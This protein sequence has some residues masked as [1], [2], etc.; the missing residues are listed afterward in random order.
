MHPTIFQRI[1]FFFM[2]TASDFQLHRD[3]ATVNNNASNPGRC[4]RIIITED[5]DPEP[6]ENFTISFVVNSTQPKGVNISINQNEAVIIIQEND[7]K[8]HWFPMMWVRELHV[9]PTSEI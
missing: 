2:Y 4:F 9:C 1:F 7:S 3:L 8:N 5:S 6:A